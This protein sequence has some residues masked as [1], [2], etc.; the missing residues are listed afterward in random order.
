MICSCGWTVF[1]DLLGLY[2]IAAASSVRCGWTVFSD[3]LGY[4]GL[5]IGRSFALRLDRLL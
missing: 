2:A 4:I 3:L 5:G 1:S